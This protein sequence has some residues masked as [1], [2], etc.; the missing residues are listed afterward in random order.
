MVKLITDSPQIFFL[1]SNLHATKIG[2]VAL[3]QA[4]YQGEARIIAY[5][6]RSFAELCQGYNWSFH[7]W[8]HVT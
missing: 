5:L 8:E 4:I 2:K 1:I 6:G 7:N 3:E